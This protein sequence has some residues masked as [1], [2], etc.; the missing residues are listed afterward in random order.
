MQVSSDN[1]RKFDDRR[2]F[3]NNSRSNNNYSNTNTNNRYNNHQLQKNRR[4]EAVRAYAVTPSGN[5]RYARDLPLCKRCNLH[6]TEPCTG[7]CNICNKV[8]HL[9]K[10]CRNKKPATRSNQL[11]V[12]VVCHACGEKGHY[13]NQ[14]RKTNINGQGRAYMLRDN[15]LIKTRTWLLLNNP[16]ITIYTFYDIE[17][18]DGNLVSTNTIIKGCTL[19]LLDQPF[20]IDLMPIKL[21]SFDVVIG[22]DWLSKYHAKILCDEKVVHIPING[23]TLIVRVMEKKSDEKRLE[24]IPVVKEFSD[25]FPEDLP[26]LPPVRQCMRTRNSY[27]PNNSNVTIPRHRHKGRALNIVEPELRTIVAPMAERTMEELLR[28]P[29]EGYGEA[30]VLPEIN[31]DHFE[32]KTNLL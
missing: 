32:I 25:V 8:G 21:D 29:T 5:N 31:A 15:M 1:K 2:T 17:M 11:P 28:A 26:G 14:C 12:T 20:E 18:A 10:N 4:Q 16:S 7:K 9:T 24:D 19:T 27:F 23:E 30:I 6:H 22:M 3:N 13:T